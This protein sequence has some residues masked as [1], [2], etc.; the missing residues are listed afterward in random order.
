MHHFV[1][2]IKKMW[3]VCHNYSDCIIFRLVNQQ[4]PPS[5][6]LPTW[7]RKVCSV[8]QTL[9]N[10][11][12]VQGIDW[13]CYCFH[14]TDIIFLFGQAVVEWAV[15]V[16]WRGKQCSGRIHSAPTIELHLPACPWCSAA[17]DMPLQLGRTLK[18][19]P[20]VSR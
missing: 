17:E 6:R 10:I 12:P 20:P 15:C 7:M 16:C 2:K 3:E 4:W 1:Y 11:F 8:C 13:L 19:H 18:P 5:I 14:V 9:S